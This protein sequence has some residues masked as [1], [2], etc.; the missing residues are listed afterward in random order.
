MFAAG[1]SAENGL[2]AL[3]SRL[4][5][6][7][8]RLSALGTYDIE[9]KRFCLLYRTTTHRTKF[10]LFSLSPAKK[11]NLTTKK[12]ACAGEHTDSTDRIRKNFNHN[13][14][15][16]RGHEE[17]KGEEDRYVDL[18]PF[19]SFV[20]FVVIPLSLFS[21]FTGKTALLRGKNRPKVITSEAK[22]STSGALVTG[23]SPPVTA[24]GVFLY[25][26]EHHGS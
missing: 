6:L 9:K 26:G 13:E 21:P 12:P 8:S 25:E 23:F 20:S 2:S 24:A 5:A 19:V 22:V 11:R 18:P 3:G 10:P 1:V 7:G 15:K 17:H 4:S 16:V 14:P